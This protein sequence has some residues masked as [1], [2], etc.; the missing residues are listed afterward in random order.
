MLW[1]EL[2][3]WRLCQDIPQCRWMLMFTDDYILCLLVSLVVMLSLCCL[4]I[5]YCE[6]IMYMCEKHLRTKT[7][8]ELMKPSTAAAG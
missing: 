4:L 5:S 6:D 1:F 3:L 7:E 2:T 8:L